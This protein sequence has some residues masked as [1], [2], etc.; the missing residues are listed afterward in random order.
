[1]DVGRVQFRR[2]DS[3]QRRILF[4]GRKN[5]SSTRALCAHRK[6][7]LLGAEAS[8]RPARAGAFKFEERSVCAGEKTG[9]ASSICE[10]ESFG[11]SKSVD[12]YPAAV[13]FTD[14]RKANG[15]ARATAGYSRAAGHSRSSDRSADTAGRE[16]RASFRNETKRT[17]NFLQLS[18]KN[19]RAAGR[20]ARQRT[21]FFQARSRRP[22]HGERTIQ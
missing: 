12:H 7:N 15:D 11:E 22:F 18:L 6:E 19:L 16:G 10:M 14:R 5:S 3:L 21:R 13:S 8:A 17:H 4:R 2:M 1:V 9:N 20:R